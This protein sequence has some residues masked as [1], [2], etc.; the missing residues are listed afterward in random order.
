[1]EN[2][3]AYFALNKRILRGDY[4]HKE[5]G[6]LC[7]LAARATWHLTWGTT[8]HAE[9]DLEVLVPLVPPI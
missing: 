8:L 6:T 2:L 7:Y 5:L 3:G 9:L 4:K 1:M